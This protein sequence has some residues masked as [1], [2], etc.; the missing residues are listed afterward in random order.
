MTEHRTL[1]HTCGRGELDLVQL[2]KIKDNTGHSIFGPSSSHMWMACPG[3]LIPNILAPDDAGEEAAY[4][5]VAHEVSEIWLRTRQKPVHLLGTNMA[6][7][8]EDGWFLIDIDRDMFKYV[9][10]AVRA[11]LIIPGDHIVEQR[12]YFSEYTPIPNQGGTMDFAAL[13]P[14]LMHVRDHKFGN[15]P[16]N[17]VYAERNPQG[18]MY[19]LG[20]FLAWDHKY[21][22]KRIIIG[23]NQPR[24]G[25]FDEWECSREE[26]LAF[27]EELRA[28]AHA[29]WRLDAPR[30]PGVKQCRFCRVRGSCAANAKL[31][32]DLLDAVWD[33]AGAPVTVEDMADFEAR[34]DSLVKPYNLQG[35]EVGTLTTEQLAKL[36]PFRSMA[37]R[38]WK[39]LEEELNR[40][41]LHGEQVKGFKLVE[42]AT[43]RKFRNPGI[44]EATLLDMDVPRKEIMKVS[45]VS[46][47]EV[48]RVL[49]RHG[50]TDDEI[51]EIL[52]PLVIKP[53]GKK[54]LA[55]ESDKRKPTTDADDDVFGPAP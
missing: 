21:H 14:G 27:G 52:K 17:I 48:E 34:L 33:A 16:E 41:A 35:R 9:E 53:A 37:E 44:A 51:I 42:S 30:V 19:A 32:E 2:A 26:L 39:A 55:L 24:L 12:V 7:D 18:M 54:V 43:H 1:S 47:A 5:T 10:E 31:Q 38:W 15:S 8:H 28:A 3:S 4:G 29:A 46:P 45:M 50:H 23:I 13:S 20:L 6:V 36:L 22:F 49:A 40:R 25:H 11:C